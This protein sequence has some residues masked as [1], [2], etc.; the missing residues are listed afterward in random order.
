GLD[1]TDPLSGHVEVAAHLLEGPAA[2]V[3]EAEA[4]L[5][6]PS[7]ARRE[8]VE[9]ALDL[10]LEQLVAGG[11]GR[12]HAGEVRDEVTQVAVLFLADRRLEAG[13]LL[14]DLHDLAHLLR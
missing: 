2:A 1:L 13:G 14:A 3:L 10:L 9:D 5:E 7:L 4:Q 6:D 8:T 11:I 12:R